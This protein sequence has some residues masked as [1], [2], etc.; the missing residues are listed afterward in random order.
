MLP[1]R[2]T[3]N[4]SSRLNRN[5]VLLEFDFESSKDEITSELDSI[6]SSED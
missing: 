1:R 2:K 5:Q 6:C 4:T 3:E